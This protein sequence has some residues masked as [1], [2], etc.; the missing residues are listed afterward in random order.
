M[1]ESETKL[2]SESFGGG[3]V[4]HARTLDYTQSVC[5][6][7]LRAYMVYTYALVIA[8]ISLKYTQKEKC[9][10]ERCIFGTILERYRTQYLPIIRIV[11]HERPSRRGRGRQGCHCL[12][13]GIVKIHL[14]DISPQSTWTII[15]NNT[16]FMTLDFMM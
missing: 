11:P 14:A 10:T 3:G 9:V 12:R 2:R 7:T 16:T 8:I 5:T 1:R 6:N 13:L 4:I 15:S